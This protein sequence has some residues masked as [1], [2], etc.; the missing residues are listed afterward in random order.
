MDFYRRL[1]EKGF[2]IYPGKLSQIDLFRIGSIGRLFPEDMNALVRGIG[3]VFTEMG[4][5]METTA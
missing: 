1:S 2:I 4:I 5:S 3:A